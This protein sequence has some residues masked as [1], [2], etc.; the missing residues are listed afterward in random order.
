M[1]ALRKLKSS[2]WGKKVLNDVEQEFIDI[3]PKKCPSLDDMRKETAEVLE[4]KTKIASAK[5]GAP[6]FAYP[7]F[8]NGTKI[9]ERWR[10]IGDGPFDVNDYSVFYEIVCDGSVC[11]GEGIFGNRAIMQ[12]TLHTKTSPLE[13]SYF[14][15]TLV[16][17]NGINPNLEY[18][19]E[20]GKFNR[21]GHTYE[22][23]ITPMYTC[24][25]TAFAQVNLL[26]LEK[27]LRLAIMSL[28]KFN[29]A[30]GDIKP[31]NIF[32][33]GGTGNWVLCG[34]DYCGFTPSGS[35]D[36]SMVDRIGP[37]VARY[38]TNIEPTNLNYQKKYLAP[39]DDYGMLA[40]TLDFFL[41]KNNGGGEIL[42]WSDPYLYYSHTNRLVE[43]R[44]PGPYLEKY[45]SV[46]NYYDFLE[47]EDDLIEFNNIEVVKSKEYD[48]NSEF[49]DSVYN[50]D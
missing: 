13:K 45:L 7:K 26:T 12:I 22:Y 9:G 39:E 23:I 6:Q 50:S 5:E 44:K 17:E 49:Y 28:H 47:K 43:N 27:Q 18:I 37:G 41:F 2:L 10:V 4:N 32:W 35:T 30:H 31:E 14:I 34:Y 46:D 1:S 33:D 19:F 8:K 48:A 24:F 36:S 15:S 11:E 29:I 16:H 21:D 25:A 20:Y 40:N 3:P 42:N 38:L